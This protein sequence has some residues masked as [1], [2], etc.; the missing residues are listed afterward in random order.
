LPRFRTPAADA[1]DIV[2]RNIA[3]TAMRV[4]GGLAAGDAAAWRA[5]KQAKD[6]PPQVVIARVGIHYRLLLRT[7]AGDLEVLDLVARQS[8]ETTLGKMR[9]A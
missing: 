5:V 2:P 8:L 9:S 1:F 4:I 6:M 3:S 7:E